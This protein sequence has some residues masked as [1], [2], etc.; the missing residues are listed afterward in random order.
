[1]VLQPGVAQVVDGP[2]TRLTSLPMAQKTITRIV[3]SLRVSWCE[4]VCVTRSF[5]PKREPSSKRR[6]PLV[7]TTCYS[8]K[9]HCQKASRLR[10]GDSLVHHSS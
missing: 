2:D 3:S 6:T 5:H 10:R 8:P 4:C 1:M 7:T 9:L